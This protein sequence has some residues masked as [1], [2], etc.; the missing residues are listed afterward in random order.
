MILKFN[1]YQI[2]SYEHGYKVKKRI[3]KKRWKVVSYHQSLESACMNLLN[4]RIL[5]ET[6][7]DIIDCTKEAEARLSTARLLLHIND[8]ADEIK[9][10][11]NDGKN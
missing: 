9:K 5:T 4:I 1:V 10:G 2:H 6:I 7:N 11:I 3:N 8:I